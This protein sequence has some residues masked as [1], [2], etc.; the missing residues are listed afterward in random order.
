MDFDKRYVHTQTHTHTYKQT[1]RNIRS[2]CKGLT[3]LIS[4]AKLAQILLLLCTFIFISYLW[5][6]GLNRQ[7]MSKLNKCICFNR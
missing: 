4:W 6:T 1:T 3:F 2:C 5:I 7:R